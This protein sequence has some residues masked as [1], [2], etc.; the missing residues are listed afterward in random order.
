[1]LIVYGDESSD[2][3]RNRIY[4][5]VGII[6]TQ[7]EWDNLEIK[8]IKRTGG[9]IFHAADCDS[10]Q[11]DFKNNSHKDNK[12]LYIDL[13]NILASSPLMGF[14]VAI[15]LK[16]FKINFPEMTN[17]DSYYYCFVRLLRYFANM[18]SYY[19]T[20]EKA[21]Y[22]FH[23]NLDTSM[24][25]AT[26]FDFIAKIPEWNYKNYLSGIAFES[27]EK[28]GIQVAD[29]FARETMK[30]F[31]NI[32]GPVQRPT[33]IP[34]QIL[35]ATERFKIDYS[36]KYDFENYLKQLDKD[37]AIKKEDYDKWLKDNKI[38]DSA[39]NKIRYLAYLDSIGFT[40]QFG[41]FN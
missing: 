27:S 28:V 24:N 15:D 11:G 39:S 41:D 1:M 29:L 16:G 5:V 18:T 26:I 8:W 17:D 19:L 37:T 30:H 40:I 14:G 21:K 23:N 31:D 3:K 36:S 6:G 2:Q 20:K 32:F 7:E 34:M 25:A 22:I 10:D 35:R 12:K 33:R 4:A 38:N 9:K 13:T